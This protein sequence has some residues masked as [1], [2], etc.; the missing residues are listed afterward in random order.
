MS[1]SQLYGKALREYL[2]RHEPDQVT[3][4]MNTVVADLED[5]ANLFLSRAAN[6]T[7]ENVEW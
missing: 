6:H 3:E 1:R 4:A 2:E 7:L 5:N